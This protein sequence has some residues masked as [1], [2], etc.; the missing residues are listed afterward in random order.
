MSVFRTPI[1]FLLVFLVP[2]AL[3]AHIFWHSGFSPAVKIVAPIG[4]IY[5]WTV[6]LLA[7]CCIT[8]IPVRVFDAF[9]PEDTTKALT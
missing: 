3:A 2:I 9:F 1:A 4:S 8:T 7:F 6:A 5:L